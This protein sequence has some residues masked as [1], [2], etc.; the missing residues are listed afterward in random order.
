M[1]D[2]N[3]TTDISTVSDEALEAAV[4]TSATTIAVGRLSS[5]AAP[6]RT[7]ERVPSD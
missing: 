4:T 7:L 6:T 5:T 1:D 2:P 3:H